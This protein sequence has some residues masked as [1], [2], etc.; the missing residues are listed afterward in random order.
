M[1]CEPKSRKTWGFQST[2]EAQTTM[3][4]EARRDMILREIDRHRDALA[5]RLREA[6]AAIEDA[7]FTEIAAPAPE[8]DA[9]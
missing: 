7:E 2:N 8:A 4:T 6:S 3:Q 5:R 9:A 1:N